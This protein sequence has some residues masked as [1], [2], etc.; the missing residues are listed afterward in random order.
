M[1]KDLG[2]EKN[3]NLAHVNLPSIDDNYNGVFATASGFGYK[4]IDTV[5]D[6]K[7]GKKVEVDGV[8][9]NILRYATATVIKNQDCKKYYANYINGKHMCA[10]IVQHNKNKPEGLCH[11]SFK[12]H[13]YT[14]F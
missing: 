6:P 11:V 13:C 14:I 2:L 8:A 4:S 12:I 9:T 5:I 7:T 10:S 3:S 1:N